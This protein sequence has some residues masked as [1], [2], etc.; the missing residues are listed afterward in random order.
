MQLPD[1]LPA[2][3]LRSLRYAEHFCIWAIRTSVACSSQCK[4]LVREFHHAFGP[5]AEGG[6]AAYH[7]VVQ[8]LGQGQRKVRIGRPGHIELTPDEISLMLMFAAGQSGD[9]D[10]FIAQARWIMG[11]DRL[12]DLA[13]GVEVFTQMLAARGHYFR[14]ADAPERTTTPAPALHIA[15]SQAC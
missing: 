9:R 1:A 5:Q 7:D 10:R 8:A 15:H 13:A 2:F 12:D 4:T 3:D 14:A 11:H 6:M